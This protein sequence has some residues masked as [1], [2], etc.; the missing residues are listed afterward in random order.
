MIIIWPN[1]HIFHDISMIFPY[2][3]QVAQFVKYLSD[4]VANDQL[5][6]LINPTTGPTASSCQCVVS[7]GMPLFRKACDLLP[8][9]PAKRQDTS[10]KPAWF[11]V[12]GSN[13]LWR[14]YGWMGGKRIVWANQNL[15][16]WRHKTM[17]LNPPCVVFFVACVSVL[18]GELRVKHDLLGSGAVF[19]LCHSL[20]DHH[21][22][23]S[24]GELTTDSTDRGR[25]MLQHLTHRLAGPLAGPLSVIVPVV[26]S[27][28][29]KGATMPRWSDPGMTWIRPR[30]RINLHPSF[31]ASVER[32]AD[33]KGLKRIQKGP[34]WELQTIVMR[35]TCVYIYIYM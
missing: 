32:Q 11:A 23:F 31:L 29:E 33:L 15:E 10:W 14:I 24:W 35:I 19:Q 3:S 28:F 2:I 20:R 5:H 9:S 1:F 21:D 16:A 22:H 25:S 26:P 30:L 13:W 27:P 12:T 6:D 34:C 17:Y 7:D 8:I 18:L 4:L